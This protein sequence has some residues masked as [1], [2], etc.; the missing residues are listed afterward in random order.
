MN[1]L[2]IGSGKMGGAVSAALAARGHAVARAAARGLD[3]TALPAADLGFE[4]G[5]AG[6]ARDRVIALLDR[7][8]PVVSGSTGWDTAPAAAEAARLGVPFLHAANFS[9]GARLLA[10]LAALA[11]AEA[12]E[13]FEPAIVDRHH[14]AKKDAPSGTALRLACAVNAARP[15]AAPVPVV[16]LRHGGQ[17]GEHAVIFEAELESLELVHRVRDRAV[18]ARGAVLAGERLLRSG[19]TGPLTLERLYEENRHV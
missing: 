12:D 19:L 11:A 15:A 3:S 14:G 4:F 13:G 16:S 8:I 5:L 1:S 2:V 6:G 7:G 10:R 18:F 9:P 17:P